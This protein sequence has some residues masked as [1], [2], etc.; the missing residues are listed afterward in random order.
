MQLKLI[1]IC[2][3]LLAALGLTAQIDLAT[4]RHPGVK[5]AASEVLE[6]YIR[7]GLDSNLALRQRG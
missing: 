3:G 5:P 1:T 7:N 2:F 4:A 6:R